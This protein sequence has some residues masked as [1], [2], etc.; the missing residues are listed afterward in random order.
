[1]IND[2]DDNG[3][4][5]RLIRACCKIRDPEM[6]LTI[7]AITD[8]AALGVTVRVNEYET[9]ERPKTSGFNLRS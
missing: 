8:A 2:L 4:V 9:E 1:M 6:R 5:L 7:I 3:E